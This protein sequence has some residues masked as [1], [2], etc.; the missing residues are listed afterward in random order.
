MFP[1]TDRTVFPWPDGFDL[2]RVTHD[3]F[4]RFNPSGVKR[5]LFGKVLASGK[6][7]QNDGREE[8]TF[9]QVTL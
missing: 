4:H 3:V 7:R 1:Q 6:K 2:P 9:H 8:D 5:G